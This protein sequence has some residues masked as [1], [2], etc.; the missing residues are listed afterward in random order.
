MT[1][2][3]TRKRKFAPRSR[4]GCITCRA[5][6]KRC[7]G[8]RPNCQ[9]C[10]RVNFVCEWEQARRL[11]R[12][13]P[14]RPSALPSVDPWD[15]RH[16]NA[17]VEQ[18]NLLT[19]YIQILVPSISVAITPSSFYTTLYIPMALESDGILNAIVA[20]SSSHLAKRTSGPD[21]AKYLRELSTKCQVQCYS[22]LRERIA[23]SGQPSRDP[24]QVVGVILLLV[25]LEALNGT[26]SQ[27]WMHQLN[28]VR[29]ILN[30]LRNDARPSNS[31][32]ELECLDRHFT[33]HDTMASLMADIVDDNTSAPSPSPQPPYPRFLASGSSITTTTTTIDPLMGLSH[34]LF[35]LLRQI[36]HL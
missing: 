9:N 27:K 7:D 22:F 33:Y 14:P 1:E 3:R 26:R 2:L 35:T 30:T 11:P 4:Q 29:A 24:Y 34:P 8:E 16:S 19:Y 13:Q 6:R 5:R 17:A 31:A 32:W 28:C 21:R 36:R 10:L 20:C 23:P 12:T 25:G 18:R 15:P